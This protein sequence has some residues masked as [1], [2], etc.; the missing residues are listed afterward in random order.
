MKTGKQLVDTYI[1]AAPKPSQPMLRELRRA[2]KT[3]APKAQ[4]SISYQMPYYSYN[5]RVAYIAGYKR[6]VSM[7]VMGRAKKKYARELKPY[8]TSKA[9]LRFPIGTR[10]PV[11]LVKKLVKDRMKENEAGE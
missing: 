5:G 7:Y 6:H 10:I 2:I 4:E 3:A 8:L 1:A 9:T 11:T